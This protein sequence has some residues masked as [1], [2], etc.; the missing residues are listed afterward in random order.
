MGNRP[1]LALHVKIALGARG[2]DPAG[3]TGPLG[4]KFQ[5]LRLRQRS[6]CHLVVLEVMTIVALHPHHTRL[7]T[8]CQ[9]EYSQKQE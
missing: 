7:D 5:G 6:A 1:F 4:L 9:G 3:A 8:K 2:D